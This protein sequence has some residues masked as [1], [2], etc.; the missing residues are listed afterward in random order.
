MSGPIS[1]DHNI[2]CLK[3]IHWGSFGSQ[4]IQCSHGLP[5]DFLVQPG[6]SWEVFVSICA[7][8]YLFAHIYPFAYICTHLHILVSICIYVQLADKFEQTL[9]TAQELGLSRQIW[10]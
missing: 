7:D 10:K 3:L 8:L 2:E 6:G 5:G 1:C 4:G 9:Y